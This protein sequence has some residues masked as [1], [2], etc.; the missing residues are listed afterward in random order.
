MTLRFSFFLFLF[1][2][3]APV[4]AQDKT[5]EIYRYA[6]QVVDTLASPSM[7]G[8]GYVNDGEKIAA[9]YIESQFRSFGLKMFDD[10]YRQKFHLNINTF[11]SDSTHHGAEIGSRGL[12]KFIPMGESALIKCNAPSR[13]YAYHKIIW[14]DSSTVSTA[15]KMERFGKSNFTDKVLVIDPKGITKKEDLAF[16]ESIKSNPV[17]AHGLV[18][19]NNKRLMWDAAQDT[20]SFPTFELLV[21]DKDHDGLRHSFEASGHFYYYVDSKLITDYKTQNLIG[22]IPGTQY[23]DSFIVFTAHYDHLGQ[24]GKE[25]YF[26]GANDNASGSAMLLSLARYY[27]KPEHAPKYS[28]AFMAFSAEEAGLV[29]SRYYAGLPLFPLKQIKFLINMDIMG[30]GDEGITVV[31][32][33]EFKPAFDALQKLN[34]KGHYLPEVKIRGKAA[35]SDHYPFYMKGVPDFFIYTRGGIKAYHDI[36]DKAETLPLTKFTD[37]FHLL[38]DFESWLESGELKN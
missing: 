14:L 27:S 29:G 16:I 19:F 23:P 30:T 2:L 25:V 17:H 4:P 1:L 7:H 24:I 26:P 6:R 9:N 3:S 8:R 33:T 20:A 32:G 22:Y 34:D 36:Y 31:N 13:N 35:N 21:E 37:V 5:S 15:K 18:I 11:P 38:T 10:S 12:D 28:I